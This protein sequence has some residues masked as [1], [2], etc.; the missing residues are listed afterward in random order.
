MRR[1]EFIAG[2]GSAAASSSVAWPQQVA[3]PTIG[4]L[5]PSQFLP[6][7]PYIEAFHR[8]LAKTGFVEGRNLAI[9]YRT[10]SSDPLTKSAADLVQRRVAVIATPGSTQAAI[11]AKAATATIPI[12]F[13]IASTL[14]KLASSQVS[15]GPAATR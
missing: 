11:V 15:A 8:G 13:G 3:L 2:L 10:G 4:F 6:G 14:S 7:N 1:R 5:N 12:V 9:E